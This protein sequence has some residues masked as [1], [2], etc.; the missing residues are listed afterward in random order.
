MRYFNNQILGLYI[1]SKF[2]KGKREAYAYEVVFLT[3]NFKEAVMKRL[4]FIH[5][6]DLHLDSPFKGMTELPLKLRER[7][8]ESTFRSLNQL[9]RLAVREQVDFVVIS[10]DVYDLA[11]RSLR[12]QIRFQRAMQHLSDRDIQAYIIHGNHDPEDGHAAKLTWPAGVHF[13]AS[14]RVETVDVQKGDRGVIAQIHGISYK[15]AAVTEN[16]AVHYRADNASIYQIGLL[17]TNVDGDPA[18]DNYAPC[19]KE[20]LLRSGIHYWALGHVHTRKVLHPSPAIVYPGNLQGRSIRETG[21]RGCYV[22]EVNEDGRAELTFHALDSLRW[23][24][25]KLSIQGLQTEQ[26]LR[27]VLDEL[28]DSLRQDA[29]GRD[30]IVRLVLEG[31]GPLHNL[32]RKGR[33]LSE[34]T[35][36]LREQESSRIASGIEAGEE[37]DRPARSKGSASA[38]TPNNEM[39]SNE[40]QLDLRIDSN[41]QAWNQHRGNEEPQIRSDANGGGFVWME[42]IEN[43]TGSELDREQLRQQKSFVGDLLRLAQ[44]LQLDEAALHAFADEALAALQALPQAAGGAAAP[45]P[46]RLQQWLRA[47]E[48]LTADLLVADG[49]WDG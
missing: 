18:H 9:V 40:H 32:L 37:G 13:F 49:G 31:R 36:D 12:A 6:A 35:A 11:D 21:P 24:E 46:E 43:R 16:L 8:R 25:E 39:S 19:S 33:T 26:E 3:E 27:D 30:C 28:K 48:E 10:G 15:T 14:D 42:S 5:A 17:H 47:A 44:S 2:S 45:T 1:R 38:R 23:Y 29:E 34:L 7:V 41:L 4:R 22:V 20:D